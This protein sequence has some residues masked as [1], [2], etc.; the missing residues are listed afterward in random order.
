MGNGLYSGSSLDDLGRASLSIT[1]LVD[2]E[3]PR[4]AMGLRIVSTDTLSAF[5]R[6]IYPLGDVQPSYSS[7]AGSW[8]LGMSWIDGATDKQKAISLRLLFYAIDSAGNVSAEADTVELVDSG[9]P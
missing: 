7:T 3:T 6:N 2:S 1:G 4:E 9:R 8:Q 5:G